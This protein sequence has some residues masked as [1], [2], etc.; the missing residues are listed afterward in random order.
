MNRCTRTENL[1]VQRKRNDAA[2][3]LAN[4]VVL[5]PECCAA[6]SIQVTF[7]PPFTEKT[8][9]TALSLAG[10]RCECTGPGNCH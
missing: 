10:K 3:D 4:T 9:E 6:T 5:C 1:V 2:N 8:R 7:W